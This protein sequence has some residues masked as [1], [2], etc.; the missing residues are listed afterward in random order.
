MTNNC[1]AWMV[2]FSYLRTSWLSFIWELLVC[3]AKKLTSNKLGTINKQ[4]VVTCYN[5][6]KRVILRP[7]FF[8]TTNK[9]LCNIN[10]I[11]ALLNTKSLCKNCYP[12]CSRMN[13]MQCE[14]IFVMRLWIILK[15]TR[16]STQEWQYV[17]NFEHFLSRHF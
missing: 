3:C 7:S 13:K 11:Y 9:K 10:F 5:K 15:I 1:I 16:T 17:A 8:S 6:H 2:H 4:I 12:K 14:K